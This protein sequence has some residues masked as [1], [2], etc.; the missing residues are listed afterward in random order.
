[1]KII[2]G[3]SI[4]GGVGKTSTSVNLAWHA[5]HSGYRTLLIDL[6]PQGAASYCFRTKA[7]KKSGLSQFFTATDSLV[8]QVKATNFA[9][10]D[11]IPAH[12]SFRSFDIE[13]STQKKSDKRLR[14]VLSKFNDD[15]DIVIL[16][17]P[18][19]LSLL[20]ENIFNTADLIL[21]PVIPAPLSERSLEQLYSFFTDRAL[22]KKKIAPFL[23]MVQSQKRVH[24]DT[25]QRIAHRFP[26]LLRTQI[27]FSADVERMTELRAPVPEFARSRPIYGHYQNLWIEVRTLLSLNGQ[28]ANTVAE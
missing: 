5:A 3:Y 14:K 22:S 25:S 26:R 8:A 10:L 7:K 1:M 20:A 16:D 19:S 13:L 6:D 11:I 17:C 9:G 18:P 2:A 27:P 15:Y 28:Q 21:V 12:L 4:K 24:I 23:S